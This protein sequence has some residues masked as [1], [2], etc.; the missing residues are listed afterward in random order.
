MAWYNPF[1]WTMTA[2]VSNFGPYAPAPDTTSNW[3][4]IDRVG[5]KRIE[6]TTVYGEGAPANS[7]S[8]ALAGAWSQWAKTVTSTIGNVANSAGG[9]VGTTL[10]KLILALAV[11]A[12]VVIGIAILAGGYSARR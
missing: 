8:E 6:P 9:F 7:A 4:E 3:S 1:S 2:G 5:G 11:L 12:V 10:N